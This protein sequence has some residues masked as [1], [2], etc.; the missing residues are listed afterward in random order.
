MP[1]EHDVLRASYGQ[2][3]HRAL[4]G[5]TG[6]SRAIPPAAFQQPASPRTYCR[7]DVFVALVDYC[8]VVRHWVRHAVGGS[9]DSL[10]HATAL[11]RAHLEAPKTPAKYR[12]ICATIRGRQSRAR[13]AIDAGRSSRN[14]GRLRA[15]PGG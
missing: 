13:P 1:A 5:E 10:E 6:F 7:N 12:D 4:A 14:S 15:S 2:K 9:S 11:S 8:T 3:A